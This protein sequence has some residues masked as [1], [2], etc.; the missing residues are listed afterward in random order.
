M[1]NEIPMPAV[2]AA[3]VLVLGLA[4]FFMWRAATPRMRPEGS[5]SNLERVGAAIKTQGK[6]PLFHNPRKD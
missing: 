2:I 6:R 5:P 3:C 1:K 4:G